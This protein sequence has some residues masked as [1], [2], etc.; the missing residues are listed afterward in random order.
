[1]TESDSEASVDVDVSSL[2]TVT[3]TFWLKEDDSTNDN[4]TIQLSDRDT[5]NVIFF[6]AIGSEANVGDQR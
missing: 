4:F 6:I 5:G 2:T 1:M 3:L